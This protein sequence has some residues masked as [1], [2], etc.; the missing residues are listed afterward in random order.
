MPIDLNEHVSSL[1]REI[2]PLG[3]DLFSDVQDSQLRDYLIDA[4]WDARL[5]GFLE[6]WRVDASGIVEPEGS[7]SQSMPR[8]KVALCVIYVGSR[9]LR[10]QIVNTEAHFRASAGPVSFESRQS[11]TVMREMLA[12]LQWRKE[13]LLE[14][15]ERTDVEVMDALTTRTLS[16]GSYGGWVL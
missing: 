14:A 6:G 5:D 8:E 10:L 16:A 1:R 4:F 3:S 9:I 7:N 13:R 15:L 12:Q 11:A 2:T